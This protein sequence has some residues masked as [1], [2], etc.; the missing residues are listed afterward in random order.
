M[1]VAATALLDSD[2]YVACFF[3]H[4]FFNELVPNTFIAVIVF[5]EKQQQ[6]QHYSSVPL[7]SKT[8]ALFNFLIPFADIVLGEQLGK[9]AFGVVYKATLKDKTIACKML[10][11]EEAAKLDEVEFLREAQTMS[12]IPSNPNV[13]NLVGFCRGDRICILSGK[14][15]RPLDDNKRTHNNCSSDTSLLYLPFRA[16]VRCR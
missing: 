11:K 10:S 2:A 4:S 16:L 5:S 9:G 1:A 7:V 15:L 6:Q 8:D 12:E 3:F 13:I 14:H